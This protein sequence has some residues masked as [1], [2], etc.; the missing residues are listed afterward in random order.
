MCAV[1]I[2]LI[3]A[4]L[5]GSKPT[6]PE[7]QS[8]FT[9]TFASI[10]YSLAFPR[11]LMQALGEAECGMYPPVLFRE[12]NRYKVYYGYVHTHTLP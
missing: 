1:V 8:Q 4:M 12:V 2:A 7:M 11:W 9:P 5:G 10:L 6:L 3:S